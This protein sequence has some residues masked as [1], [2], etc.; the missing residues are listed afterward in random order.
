MR[1]HT[2][3]RTHTHNHAHTYVAL[4]TSERVEQPDPTFAVVGQPQQVQLKCAIAPGNL[5]QQYY[6]TWYKGDDIIYQTNENAPVFSNSERYSHNSSNLAL[7]ISIVELDDAS[8]NYHCVLRVVNPL[9]GTSTPYNTLRRLSIRLVVL[10]K[11]YN[12]D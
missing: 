10:G 9:T 7:T 12:C 4:P 6:V 1:A 5:L 2:H 3:T 11:C 8:D